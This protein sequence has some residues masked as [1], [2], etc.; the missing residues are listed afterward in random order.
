MRTPLLVS[1]ALAVT[2]TL[3]AQATIPSVSATKDPNYYEYMATYGTTST[4][5]KNEGRGQYL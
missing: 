1:A 3:S 4:S 2:T 5:I